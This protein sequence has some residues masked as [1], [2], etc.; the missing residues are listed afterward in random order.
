MIGAP[1]RWNEPTHRA[2]AVVDGDPRLVLEALHASLGGPDNDGE[3]GW[4]ERWRSADA[5]AGR[6]VEE[7]LAAPGDERARPRACIRRGGRPASWG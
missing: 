1:G 2:G 3:P 6:A 5:A 4:A 7:A